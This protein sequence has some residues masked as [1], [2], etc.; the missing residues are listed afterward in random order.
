MA[1]SEAII[2]EL[3][4]FGEDWT[5]KDINVNHSLKEVDIHLEYTN[6][7]DFFSGTLDSYSIYDYNVERRVRH[8]D[9]FDYKTFIVFRNPRVKNNKS[10]VRIIEI[11]VLA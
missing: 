1:I 2:S 10:D 6:K 3:L 7:M 5:I 8:M 9:L 11:P 4:G